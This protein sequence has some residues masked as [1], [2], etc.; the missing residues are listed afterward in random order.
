MEF[1]GIINFERV[2]V[3]NR[4]YFV[5]MHLSK[6]KKNNYF[7]QEELLNCLIDPMVNSKWKKDTLKIVESRVM[8]QF[9]ATL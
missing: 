8:F 1:K 2:Y 5:V 9:I 7:E 4:I 6:K 3:R